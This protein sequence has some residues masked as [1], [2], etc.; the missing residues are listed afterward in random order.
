METTFP[1]HPAAFSKHILRFFVGELIRQDGQVSHG[2]GGVNVPFYS[3]FLVPSPYLEI[4]IKLP[5]HEACL[6][7]SRKPVV[8]CRI[9]PG[10]FLSLSPACFHRRQLG[11]LGAAKALRTRFLF[12]NIDALRNLVRIRKQM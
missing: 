6:D 10:C 3:R 2:D 5:G 8:F 4:P 7:A 1:K 9:A 12:Q 11:E